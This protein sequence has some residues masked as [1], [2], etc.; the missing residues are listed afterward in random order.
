LFAASIA[1]IP[2]HRRES[3]LRAVARSTTSR[4]VWAVIAIVFEHY[5]LNWT[6]KSEGMFFFL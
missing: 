6:K 4:Y 2:A 3:I 1:D 5:C